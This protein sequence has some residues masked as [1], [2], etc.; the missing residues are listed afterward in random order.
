MVYQY[1]A[2]NENGQI[3][4]GKLAASTE[5]VAT[6]L[7]SYAGYR[8]VSLKPFQG[9]SDGIFQRPRG[10]AEFFAG[11]GVAQVLVALEFLHGDTREKRAFF[12]DSIQ[13]RH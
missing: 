1:L 11:L 3:V 6:E 10:I 7:L 12:S 4:K 8:A 9:I 5:E 13:G 2:Y